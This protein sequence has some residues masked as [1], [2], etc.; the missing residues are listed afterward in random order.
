MRIPNAYDC[1]AA[2]AAIAA[3]IA[4]LAG[5]MIGVR[6]EEN[7]ITPSEISVGAIGAL[8]GPIAFIGGARSRQ[9][10]DGL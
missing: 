7:G 8:T 3:G 6:A 2:A 4:F 10:D 5:P 9:P 1:M